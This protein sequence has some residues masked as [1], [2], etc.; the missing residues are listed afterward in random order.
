MPTLA[1]L[2]AIIETKMRMKR[3]F[4][5]RNPTDMTRLKDDAEEGD[6]EDIVFREEVKEVRDFQFV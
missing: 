4:D 1:R 6:D 2:N 3:L 5:L